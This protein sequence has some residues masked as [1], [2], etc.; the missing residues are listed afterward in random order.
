MTQK[1]MRMICH[2][3][4]LSFTVQHTKKVYHGCNVNLN[5]VHSVCGVELSLSMP[6]GQFVE[7]Y[8]PT[9]MTSKQLWL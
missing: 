8:S 9:H 6:Q 3:S 4:Q 5:I 1:L 2:D 7:T